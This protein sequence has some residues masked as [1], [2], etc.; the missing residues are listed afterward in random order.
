MIAAFCLTCAHVCTATV[1]CLL[2]RVC[3]SS[4]FALVQKRSFYSLGSLSVDFV[5]ESGSALHARCLF[6][7]ELAVHFF[8]AF[9]AARAAT[10]LL[11]ASGTRR[12]FTLSAFTHASTLLLGA[13]SLSTAGPFAEADVQC[14][15]WRVMA[16]LQHG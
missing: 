9:V 14:C 8:T 3:R 10:M 15:A 5:S 16:V 13:L 6:T 7:L 2:V 1:F 4:V 11:A 12:H